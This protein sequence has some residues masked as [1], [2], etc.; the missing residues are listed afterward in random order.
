M[1]A[2]IGVATLVLTVGIIA[3]WY[4][5]HRA[6]AKDELA[7]YYKRYLTYQHALGDSLATTVDFV[8]RDEELRKALASGNDDAARPIIA[9]AH[10]ILQKS[11]HPEILAVVDRHGDV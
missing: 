11:Y 5:Y 4:N 10:D 7:P 6:T 2:N 1:F 8:A 3:N 9:R